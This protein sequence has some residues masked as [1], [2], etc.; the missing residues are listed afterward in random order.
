MH[1]DSSPTQTRRTPRHEA[2]PHTPA[3]KRPRSVRTAARRVRAADAIVSQW[4]L[5]QLPSDRR[6][7]IAE[8]VSS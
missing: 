1:V 4:L 7:R 6:V 8:P 3:D 5:E 2:T